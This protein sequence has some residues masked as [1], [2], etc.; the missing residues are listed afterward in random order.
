MSGA[1]SP[2]GVVTPF[3]ADMLYYD[4][5]GDQAWISTG[6]ANTDWEPFSGGGGGG[7]GST[8]APGEHLLGS[9]KLP[10]PNV[11]TAVA[12][13]I[14]YARTLISAGVTLTYGRVYV[15][16][17]GS[18][19]RLARV[20]I[21]DQATPMSTTGTPNNLLAQ[22]ATFNTNTSGLNTVAL[23]VPYAVTTTGYYWI[24]FVCNSNAI[25][26]SASDVYPA[27]YIPVYRETGVGL[28]LPAT[29]GGLTNPQS[30]VV[31]ASA[32]E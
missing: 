29:A 15:E 10:Y 26:W 19:V 14:Q 25:R 24:A 32:V 30:A 1:G 21:Y 12:S 20:G 7:G 13:R 5:T 27:N 2:V 9:S 18:L 16:S 8:D 11:G 4:T 6:V 17:N 23:G 31:Y 22:T 28:T 3:I